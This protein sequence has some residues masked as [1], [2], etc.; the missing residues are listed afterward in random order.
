MFWVH[1]VC[2]LLEDVSA[3][4]ICYSFQQPRCHL[5]NE[6]ASVATA[7]S[8]CNEQGIVSADAK[9]YLARFIILGREVS[10][11]LNFFKAFRQIR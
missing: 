4:S 11:S 5:L 10:K 8:L 1:L 7:V 3:Q 2:H 6:N 9:A